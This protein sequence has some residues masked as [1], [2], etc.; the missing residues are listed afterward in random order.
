[1]DI[2]N[3]YTLR[4]GVKITESINKVWCSLTKAKNGKLKHHAFEPCGINSYTLGH[5]NRLFN[6][7]C[8]RNWF[9]ENVIIGE[10]IK[11]YSEGFINGYTQLE[12]EY[13][14][15]P[16]SVFDIIKYFPYGEHYVVYNKNKK[17]VPSQWDSY[18]EKVG[19][20]Y[21]AWC[22]VLRKQQYYEPMFKE[23]VTVN[24]ETKPKQ[25]K[26]LTLR[27]IALIYQYETFMIVPSTKANEN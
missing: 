19:G 5:I 4:K 23:W 7:A 27:Q 18:G 2:P 14:T 12:N 25:K 20:L 16:D 10:E 1:M 6:L 3:I 21:C 8:H 24:Q 15:F 26:D 11:K 9:D 13:T 17:I 22:I